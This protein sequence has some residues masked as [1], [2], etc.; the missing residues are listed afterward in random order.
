MDS[1]DSDDIDY[2]SFRKKALYYFGLLNV[3]LMVGGVL[4]LPIC[5][6]LGI[7]FMFVSGG[8]LLTIPMAF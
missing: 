4:L 2:D 6:P 3:G 1:D 8:F 5:P 7:M